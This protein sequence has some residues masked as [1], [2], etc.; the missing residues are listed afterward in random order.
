MIQRLQ[1]VYLFVASLVVGG[2]FLI[3]EVWTGPAASSQPWFIPTSMGI[4]GLAAV[5]A[6]LCIFLYKDQ[7]RQRKVVMGVQLIAILAIIVLFG[8]QWTAG[9]LPDATVAGDSFGEWIVIV[10][11][12]VSYVLMY[13]A[14]RGIDA[15]I[16][17]IRSM[18]RLR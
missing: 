9:T 3:D 16:K 17:L 2:T 13:M 15:D 18:D 8:G 6:F 12:F 14:R 5:G 11:P 7:K 1:T 10:F 4:L